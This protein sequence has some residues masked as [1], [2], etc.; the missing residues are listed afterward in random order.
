MTYQR[1]TMG[2]PNDLCTACTL[3]LALSRLLVSTSGAMYATVPTVDLGCDAYMF[4]ANKTQLL[5]G[6]QAGKQQRRLFRNR[7]GKAARSAAVKGAWRRKRHGAAAGGALS[8][9]QSRRS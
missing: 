1:S 3:Y 2:V 4:C 8:S 9:S 7:C 6:R 5:G